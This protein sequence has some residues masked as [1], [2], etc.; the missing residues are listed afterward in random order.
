MKIG[1]PYYVDKLYGGKHRKMLHYDM[2]HYVSLLGT[3]KMLLENDKFYDLVFGKEEQHTCTPGVYSDFCD[4]SFVKNHPLLSTDSASSDTLQIVGYYDELETN[5]PLGPNTKKYKLGFVFFTVANLHPKYR[6]N[7][8]SIFLSTIVNYPLVEAHGLNKILQPFVDDLNHLATSGVTVTRGS[9]SVVYKGVLIAFLADNLAS[10]AVGGFKKSMSFARHFCRS[11]LATKEE[12]CCM[13]TADQFKKRTHE[14]YEQMCIDIAGDTTGAFSTQYGINERSILNDVPGFS[15]IGGLCH[16]FFHDLLEGS[17]NYEFKLLLQHL[18]SLKYL[19]LSQ[20]NERIKSFNYGYS[21]TASK[22]N[23][24]SARCFTAENLKI[25]LSAS[26]MLLIAQILPFLIK[27][28]VPDS[29][30]EYQCFPKLIEIVQIAYSPTVSDDVVSYLHVIIE[31]HHIAFITLYPNASF[32]P[33]LHY[34]IHYPEQILTHGPLVWAWTMRHEA[35]LNYFKQIAKLGNFKNITSTLS[36]RHR[37]WLAYH[38]ATNNLFTPDTVR[39]PLVTCM[40]IHDESDL[41]QSLCSN[42]SNFLK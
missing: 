37:Q 3:L 28:K 5:N 35:K 20:L 9:T 42:T 18:F 15:V 10:H 21:E 38:I 16:D 41:M 24:I 8:K 17:L 14:E 34:I 2:F 40:L 12:S 6:S 23:E 39:G 25:R 11:C 7:Y 32:I 27:D 4:G 30:E 26:E 13:F 1:S 19:S 29:D 31:E 33:K 36:N 22:P